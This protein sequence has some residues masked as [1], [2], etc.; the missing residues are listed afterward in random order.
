MVIKII[1]LDSCCW[2]LILAA[3]TVA[4]NAM[5]DAQQFPKVR[6]APMGLE[7]GWEAASG[8]VVAE[9][10]NVKS[11]GSTEA[12]ELPWPL[13]RG[14]RQIYWCAADIEVSAVIKG[15]KPAQNKPYL[16]GTVRPGRPGCEDPADRGK[17]YLGP[18]MTVWF[19]REE[20]QYIRPVVDIAGYRNFEVA[21]TWNS[22]STVDPKIQFAELLL[23]P[24]IV[25]DN[26]DV[27][28]LTFPNFAYLACELLGR[29]RCIQRLNE[30]SALNSRELRR[31]ACDLLE[32]QFEQECRE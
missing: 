8:V 27:F 5:C 6:V 22:H 17:R 32:S 21:G 18:T 29:Q 23:S 19:I 26:I 28:A 30:L 3:L 11:V 1:L 12:D 24:G 4:D 15:R 13:P 16:W 31:K 9:I 10:R 20:G 2:L 25:P 7:G 14:I